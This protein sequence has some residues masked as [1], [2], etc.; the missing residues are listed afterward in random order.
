[1]IAAQ[2]NSRAVELALEGF[3]VKSK[4]EAKSSTLKVAEEILRL[5]QFEVPHDDGTLQNSGAAEELPNG[6]VVVGYHT[7]YAARLHEHPEYNFQKGRK[8][9]YLEDP[10]L[11]NAD[12]LGLN[13]GKNIQARLFK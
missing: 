6:D 10:I 8:G 1:M 5:S 3:L 9:K 11:N 4:L 7:Q 2:I 13:F 12:V